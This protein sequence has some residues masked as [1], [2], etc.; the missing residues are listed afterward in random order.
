MKIDLSGKVAVVTGAA[1]NG[2]GRQHALN[3][4][5]A[6]ARL[7][8]ID[9]QDCTESLAFLESKG[10]KAKAFQV[11]ITDFES[12]QKVA[13]QIESED[14]SPQIIVNNASIITT[15][16]MFADI[17]LDRWQRDIQVNLV[18]SANVTRAFWKGMLKMGWG[19][20][21]FISSIAGTRG[22][23]GQTSYAATK[24]GVIGLAK[25][26][27]LEGASKGVTV[28]AVAP[29]VLETEAALKFIR[30]DMLDR[31][32]KSIPLRRFG[33]P[34]NIS[35]VVTFLCSEQSEYITGQVLE[36]DG[37]SGLFVF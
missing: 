34:K 5:L 12:L 1:S 10:V 37:G 25:S 26:L 15:V 23:A 21:V 8:L 11:D 7:C 35:D 32:K 31:M 18:G 30:D 16:G 36:V 4:G 17:P 19:R 29:G 2:L 20:V 27:A 33:T 24:A 14:Q 3:L 28:N 9:V 22:G 6:G 13:D